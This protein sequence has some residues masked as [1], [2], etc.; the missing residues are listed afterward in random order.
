MQPGRSALEL[1]PETV[2]EVFETLAGADPEPMFV[3]V[4]ALD[5]AAQTFMR[6]MGT[7]V[8]VLVP[9]TARGSFFGLLNV[10]VTARPERLRP[11]AELRDRLAGVVAHAATALANG[12][13]V[14]RITR[15][16]RH[17]SLTGLLGH[18]AFQSV[19][20]PAGERFSVALADIDDFKAVN[21]THGHLTGDEALRHV[22]ETLLRN[23]RDQDRVFRVGGEEF[24]VLM[25]GLDQADAAAVA[26][27]LRLAVARGGFTLPVRISIGVATY[28]ADGASRDDLLGRADAALYTAKRAGKNRTTL[29]ADVAA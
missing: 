11:T 5:P 7:E 3:D 29:A 1:T 19:D 9:I 20:A 6:E 13:L 26:E 14:D 2:P 28:P 25:P 18:G 16:A 24:C 22:A 10:D 15:E 4:R 23:V 21:D 12:R 8:T 17:D 27:R